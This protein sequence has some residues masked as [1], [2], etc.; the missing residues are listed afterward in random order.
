MQT[1]DGAIAMAGPRRTAA[2]SAASRAYLSWVHV[3][4]AA[5]TRGAAV[6]TTILA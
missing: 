6:L 4:S 2:S 3:T 5:G 1:A